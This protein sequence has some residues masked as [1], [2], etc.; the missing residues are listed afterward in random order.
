M[1]KIIIN[2]LFIVASIILVGFLWVGVDQFVRWKWH[3][4]L[5]KIQIAAIALPLGGIIGWIIF[6]IYFSI[7]STL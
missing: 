5:D 2:L 1:S 6:I 7:T 3:K 4:K